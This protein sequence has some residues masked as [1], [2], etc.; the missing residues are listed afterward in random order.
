MAHPA[1][2]GEVHQTGSFTHDHRNSLQDSTS[3]RILLLRGGHIKAQCK[4]RISGL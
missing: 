3:D 4:M 1:Y 2:S